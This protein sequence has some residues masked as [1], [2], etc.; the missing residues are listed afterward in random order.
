ME[1]KISD[2]KKSVN[3][4]N[5]CLKKSLRMAKLLLLTSY[6]NSVICV[7]KN[8]IQTS[9]TSITFFGGGRKYAENLF[10]KIIIHKFSNS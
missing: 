2:Y 8:T 10:Q 1:H 9:E 6:F 4:S 7:K 5:L 3:P